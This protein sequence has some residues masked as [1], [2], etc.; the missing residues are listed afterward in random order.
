VGEVFVTLGVSFAV[1]NLIVARRSFAQ[2]LK[3]SRG[4]A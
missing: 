3:A 4:V 1:Q 2:P